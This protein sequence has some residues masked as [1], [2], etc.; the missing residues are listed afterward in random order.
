MKSLKGI[1]YQS[2]IIEFLETE[3]QWAFKAIRKGVQ[4]GEGRVVIDPAKVPLELRVSEKS[5]PGNIPWLE[6]I[7]MLVDTAD[8]VYLKPVDNTVRCQ[9]IVHRINSSTSLRTLVTQEDV[10]AFALSNWQKLKY[11]YATKNDNIRFYLKKMVTH[12]KNLTART[13]RI[14]LATKMFSND[15]EDISHVSFD[16]T[17]SAA[18]L[19]IIDWRGTVREKETGRF[20]PNNAHCRLSIALVRRPLTFVHEYREEFKCHA[21]EFEGEQIDQC[22]RKIEKRLSDKNAKASVDLI[23][24]GEQ[25]VGDGQDT[26]E[27]PK[28]K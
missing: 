21:Y 23:E 15:D 16:A 10:D 18:P 19:E 11:F 6:R 17:G 4:A 12:R 25:L 24:E 20:S 3:N 27:A 26:V 14:E 28:R 22:R 5:S 8:R 7:K 13:E 1:V 9:Q 2:G